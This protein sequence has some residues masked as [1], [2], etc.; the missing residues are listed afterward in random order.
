MSSEDVARLLEKQK[1]TSLQRFW[2][3]EEIVNNVPQEKKIYENSFDDSKR[4]DDRF[5]ENFCMQDVRN[6]NVENP[7]PI[8][9]HTKRGGM[10]KT[11]SEIKFFDNNDNWNIWEHPSEESKDFD[12]EFSMKSI[13][14]KPSEVRNHREL[15]GHN[16]KLDTK[17]LCK[18]EEEIK[19]EDSL[20]VSNSISSELDSIQA[21]PQNGED[22]QEASDGQ[23]M[24]KET[25]AIASSGNKELFEI[26][27]TDYYDSEDEYWD[28]H[29]SDE[30]FLDYL[31]DYQ[32][33]PVQDSHKGRFSKSNCC[34]Y[35]YLLVNYS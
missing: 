15:N 4:T 29:P 7:G 6:V 23:T 34:N 30:S 5:S 2:K 31:D 28:T 32:T 20:L 14:G 11:K 17:R 9:I 25:E 21:K 26:D 27:E 24:N 33:L 35:S 18:S 8:G 1:A 10:D 12:E 19:D 13:I 22:K 3:K 16:K